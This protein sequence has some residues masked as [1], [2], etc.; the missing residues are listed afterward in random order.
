M[1]K[2]R[3]LLSRISQTGDEKNS[4]STIFLSLQDGT[5]GRALLAEEEGGAAAAFQEKSAP[6]FVSL[7]SETV[8]TKQVHSDLRQY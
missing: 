7:G 4:F 8:S 5:L 6:S 3:R 2:P 1:K